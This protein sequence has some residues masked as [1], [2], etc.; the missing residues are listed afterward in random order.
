MLALRC[1]FTCDRN[2]R[3]V[4]VSNSSNVLFSECT[5]LQVPS[6]THGAASSRVSGV[7][8]VGETCQGFIR[9]GGY[10]SASTLFPRLLV[11]DS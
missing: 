7:L 5:S 8:L 6:S 11:V 3:A 10:P 9:R 4:V 1:V 2:A